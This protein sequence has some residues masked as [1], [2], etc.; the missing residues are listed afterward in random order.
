MPIFRVTIRFGRQRYRYHVE[1]V[2]AEDL[3]TALTVTA[4]H[5]P[6]EAASGDL[7]EIRVLPEPDQ[8]EYTPE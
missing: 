1:D 5:L 8:R 3:R 7:A 4:G 2:E 6:P